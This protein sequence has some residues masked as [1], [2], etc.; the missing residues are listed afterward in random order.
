MSSSATNVMVIAK[1]ISAPY[2][3]RVFYLES[4]NAFS[5]IF[6]D[7]RAFFLHAVLPK[8][9]KVPRL[10]IL[11]RRAFVFPKRHQI[12]VAELLALYSTRIGIRFQNIVN[13]HKSYRF[14]DSKVTFL[15]GDF[16]ARALAWLR[17]HGATVFLRQSFR[18]CFGVVIHGMMSS[19]AAAA[20]ASSCAFSSASDNALNSIQGS[21]EIM[22]NSS[23]KS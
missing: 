5:D 17:G 15:T 2:Q 9:M 7:R 22:L 6:R 16:R 20:S 12:I 1:I 23:C 21:A 11:K 19:F 14:S 10:D 8:I 18:F 13:C 3:I 4:V